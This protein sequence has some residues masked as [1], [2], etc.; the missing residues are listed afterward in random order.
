MIVENHVKIADEQII[1]KRGFFNHP[2]KKRDVLKYIIDFAI[3]KIPLD[4]V[5][6]EL[7]GDYWGGGEMR[8]KEN[9]LKLGFRNKFDS[10]PCVVCEGGKNKEIFSMNAFRRKK[11][12]K[13]LI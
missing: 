1:I 2:E 11:E 3:K 5:S 7:H 13:L 4:R 9:Y 10:I 8:E 6:E 12:E